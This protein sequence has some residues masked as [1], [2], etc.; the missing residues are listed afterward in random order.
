MGKFVPTPG[1]FDPYAFPDT[2]PVKEAVRLMEQGAPGAPMSRGT[3]QV[4]RK[5]E[6]NFITG[7]TGQRAMSTR[8]GKQGKL[9]TGSDA[10]IL[11][12]RDAERMDGHQCSNERW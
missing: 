8:C 5:V 12:E 9:H 7:Q 3:C 4:A 10:E 2:G 11:A 6:I 1:Q